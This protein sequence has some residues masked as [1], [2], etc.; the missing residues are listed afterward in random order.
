MQEEKNIE[1]ELERLR[2]KMSQRTGRRAM[3]QTPE[4]RAYAKSLR[5]E[6]KPRLYSSETLVKQVFYDLKKLEPNLNQGK[7][8][9]QYLKEQKRAL[10]IFFGAAE[11][12]R[13]MTLMGNVGSGKS[14]LM[15]ALSTLSRITES[16][17]TFRVLSSH[18]IVDNYSRTGQDGGDDYLRAINKQNI[19]IDDLGAER[20]SHRYQKEDLLARLIEIRAT[21]KKLVT[22]VVTNLNPSELTERYGERVSSRLHLMTRRAILGGGEDSIDWRK[23]K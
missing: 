18:E 13:G 4:M 5:E 15:E 20:L 12:G 14:L 22:H 7:N 1:Q 3:E 6:R 9:E 21:K 17:Q 23:E 10:E 11:E 2:E 19:C 16:V 8:L